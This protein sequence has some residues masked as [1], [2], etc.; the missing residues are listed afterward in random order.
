M[1]IGQSS[2]VAFASQLLSSIIGFAATVLIARELGDS[3]LG[4]YA[5]VIAVVIWLKILGGLGV[6]T[7]LKK[8]LSEPTA[9]GPY[10]SASALLQGGLFVT[11]VAVLLVA[12]DYVT[13]YLRGT[14]VWIV[15]G[16]FAT[17]LLFSFITTALEGEDKVHISTALSPLDRFVRSSIQITAI[18]LGLGLTAL[19]FGYAVGA[20]LA[21]IAGI[22]FLNVRFAKPA[23]QHIDSITS[24]ARYSWLTNLSNR[25]FASMDTLVLGLFV[26]EGLIGVYEASWNLASILALFSV[27]IRQAVFPTMSL[28]STEG[29]HEVASDLLSDALTFSGL[30][31]IPGFIGSVLVGDLLLGIYGPAFVKGHLILV[32]LVGARTVYAY[33]DQ[34]VNVLNAVDRPDAAFRIDLLF[35]V[36]NVVLNLVLVWTFG[37]IGAAV[38]TLV[39][40]SAALCAG[41]WSVAAVLPVTV[42]TRE[43]GRQLMAAL[44]MGLIVA[45][46]RY[47]LPETVTVGIILAGIGA[48]MYFLFLIRLSSRFREVVRRNLPS[49]L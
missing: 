37:W 2:L 47:L 46:G 25:A 12:R 6:Q 21:S 35:T 22:F 30:L 7:A 42:P 5:L 43:L 36:T 39:S 41:Y 44:G 27:S 49:S 3:A 17:A 48:S 18:L 24:Y 9:G 26:A 38:G 33:E 14:S 28:S 31:L 20:I 1:R 4:I 45:G 19:F 23:K 32:L 13:S 8:R 40:A 29:K 34:L 10:L 11:I 16:L 15:V